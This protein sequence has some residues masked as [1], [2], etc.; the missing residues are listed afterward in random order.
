MSGATQIC[1]S[2]VSSISAVSLFPVSPA[3]PGHLPLFST[4]RSLSL[5]LVPYHSCS[6]LIPSFILSFSLLPL[7]F[8]FSHIFSNCVLSLSRQVSIL[9]QSSRSLAFLLVSFSFAPVKNIPSAFLALLPPTYRPLSLFLFLS[10]G[11][12]C[13]CVTTIIP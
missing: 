1:S 10:L 2:N 8:S 7:S 11:V 9:M 3:L 5:F 12:M 4:S 13:I 6:P